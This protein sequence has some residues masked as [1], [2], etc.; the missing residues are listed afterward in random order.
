MT[1]PLTIADWA[2][3]EARFRD[4]YGKPTMKTNWCL[5]TNTSRWT[6]TSAKTSPFHLH[7]RCGKRLGK[8]CVSDEIVELAE[9]RLHF[10]AQLKELA[11][12]DVSDNMRDSVAEG[13]T[14]QL[15]AKLEALK[16]EYEAKI[17]QA[18][19]PVPA[20]DRQA[21]CRRPVAGS[22]NDTVAQLLEKAEQ[23]EGPAF[24]APAGLDFWPAR[25]CERASGPGCRS[26]AAP[27]AAAAEA[28]RS[29]RR[30]RHG[31]RALY[32]HHPLHVL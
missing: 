5:S 29:G 27:A 2:L 19:D 25:R 23:W 16:A 32:R 8:I 22:A 4:H 21:A 10:W 31:Q 14:T 20:A 28:A 1:L 18:D 11:G 9:E 26:R 15:E 3:G 30:R 6:R 17:T 13:L 24:Q 7:G 12:I